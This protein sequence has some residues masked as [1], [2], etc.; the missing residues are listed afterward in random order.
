MR[1]TQSFLMFRY[2]PAALLIT[3][4]VISCT[5]KTE[6]KPQ[7]TPAEQKPTVTYNPYKDAEITVEIFKVDSSDSNGA[8][9]WGYDIMING[10]LYIHQPNIPAVMGNSGFSS[11]EKAREAGEMIVSKIRNNILPPSVT[12]EELESR[13]LLE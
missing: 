3:S 12:V 6:E 4:L 5:G 11:E 9:G 10:Q 2:L 13:G 7:D 1:F 8:T